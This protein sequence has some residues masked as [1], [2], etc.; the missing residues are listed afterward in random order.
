M[1]VQRLFA[2]ER[3]TTSNIRMFVESVELGEDSGVL[4]GFDRARAK[5]DEHSSSV[6]VRAKVE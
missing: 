1:I 2:V 5:W 4:V 6:Q 3:V